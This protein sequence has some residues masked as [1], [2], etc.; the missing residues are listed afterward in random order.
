MDNQTEGDG[1]A[2]GP[3]GHD[4]RSNGLEIDEKRKELEVA[5][6][7][8]G[9]QQKNNQQKT[10][11]DVQQ[12]AIDSHHQRQAEQITG[13]TPFHLQKSSETAPNSSMAPP[14]G[15]NMLSDPGQLQSVV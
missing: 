11:D 15:A 4:G 2:N 14:N 13:A 5:E 8:C 6:I 12:K 9:I 10:G 7:M 3:S 1:T